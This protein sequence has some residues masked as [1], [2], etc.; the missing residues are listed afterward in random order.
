MYSIIIYTLYDDMYN[1]DPTKAM[2][3]SMC[4]SLSFLHIGCFKPVG[5]IL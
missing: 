3:S 2:L 5:V 4:H 1:A